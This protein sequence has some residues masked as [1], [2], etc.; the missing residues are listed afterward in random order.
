MKIGL[1]RH[2]KVDYPPQK[3]I[4]NSDD[5][6]KS[7][8]VY[9]SS[10]VLKKD[11]SINPDEW[12]VCYSSTMPRAVTTAEELYSG[13][14]VKTDDIR[15]VQ[16]HPYFN[17]RLKIPSLVWRILARIAWYRSHPS[18]EENIKNTNQRVERFFK[19]ITS[20]NNRSV[21]VVT[22]GFFMRLLAE[23]LIKEGYKGKY[24]PIPRNA[25]LYLFKK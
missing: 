21:L 8:D 23:R 15:E 5:F 18:Q 9:D 12:D 11:I 20:D 25:K 1:I 6:Q 22:H 10:G 14:I 13:S 7:M 3:K 17:T 24:D 2:F 4:M 16:M 19:T